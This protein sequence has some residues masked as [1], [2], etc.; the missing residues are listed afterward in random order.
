M[1]LTTSLEIVIPDT[2][3][4]VEII[5]IGSACYP[6]GMD[7]EPETVQQALHWALLSD[8]GREKLTSLGA[9]WAPQ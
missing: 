1:G 7:G 3:S 2:V 9:I 4:E 6:D 5:R 8:W